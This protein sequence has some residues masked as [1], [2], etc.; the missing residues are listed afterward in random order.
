MA[1]ISFIM[2]AVA[3]IATLFALVLALVV[4]LSGDGVKDDTDGRPR[5]LFDRMRRW[6]TRSTPKLDYRRDKKG[7]FRKVRRG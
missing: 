1:L 4:W 2:I 3:V 6:L 7:R 5:R